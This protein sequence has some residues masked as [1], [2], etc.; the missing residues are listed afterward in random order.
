MNTCN[1]DVSST[2]CYVNLRPKR[3]NQSHLVYQLYNAG[4]SATC[5]R[6][7]IIHIFSLKAFR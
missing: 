7:N 2:T 4:I 6:V 3:P 5:C 1:L